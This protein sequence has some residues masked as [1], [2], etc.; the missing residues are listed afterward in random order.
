MSFN[1]LTSLK[2]FAFDLFQTE[3][4]EDANE[5]DTMAAI[6][7]AAATFK[8]DANEKIAKVAALEN[9]FSTLQTTVNSLAEA[10]QKAL[11]EIKVS[12][13]KVNT[14][15]AKAIGEFR[16]EVSTALTQEPGDDNDDTTVAFRSKQP[17]NTVKVNAFK[18]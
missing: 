14:D 6:N 5:V 15:T 16:T 17:T 4:A 11:T 3:I 8:A 18:K 7:D 9:D 1:L 10:T 12:V 2:K 13:E